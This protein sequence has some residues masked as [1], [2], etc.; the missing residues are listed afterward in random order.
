MWNYFSPWGKNTNKSRA[1]I[2]K[3][4]SVS[5]LLIHVVQGIQNTHTKDSDKALKLSP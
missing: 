3:V 1:H 2:F 5:A 4:L